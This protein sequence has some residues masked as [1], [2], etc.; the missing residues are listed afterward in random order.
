MSEQYKEVT[1][2]GPALIPAKTR[3]A[4]RKNQRQNGG[5]ATHLERIVPQVTQALTNFGPT[6]QSGGNTGAIVNL[7]STSAP[8]PTA[9]SVP[10][11]PLVSGVSAGQPAPIGGG[12]TLAPKRKSRISL[13]PKKGLPTPGSK[14]VT[15]K[16]R[17]INFGSKGVTAR[18][19][20]AKKV[21]KD[22]MALPLAQVK[23]A[24]ER[25]KVIK[26]TSKAPEHMLRNMY[27]DLLITKKGL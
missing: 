24:L 15:H 9:G 16:A 10:P 11:A 13:K 17:K 26:K 27:A 1:V 4:A 22:S 5:D 23:S 21:K 20:R 14:P 19:M 3:K 6:K 7:A 25:A 2:K 18:L 12:V 8:G